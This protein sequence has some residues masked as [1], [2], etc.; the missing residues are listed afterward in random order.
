M[1]SPPKPRCE[2]CGRAIRSR[3]KDPPSHLFNR[4]HDGDEVEVWVCGHAC[5]DAYND[6]EPKGPPSRKRRDAM[7]TTTVYTLGQR[8]PDGR[9]VLR[10][11]EQGRATALSVKPK[12]EETTE[13][14]A[15]EEPKKRFRHHWSEETVKTLRQDIA[16]GK[17]TYASIARRM[18][19]T[20][21]TVHICLHKYDKK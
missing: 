15:P 6:N 2:Q 10:V 1:E 20:P 9:R 14:A 7:A 19:L 4:L 11:D 12:Q 21:Q 18:G 8:L 17:E 3:Q 13:A 5:Y 16:D